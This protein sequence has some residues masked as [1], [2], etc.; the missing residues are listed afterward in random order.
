MSHTCKVCSKECT[1]MCTLC[2]SVYY[3]D[4]TCQR[5]D[6]KTHKLTCTGKNKA[7]PAPT[8]APTPNPASSIPQRRSTFNAR[9]IPTGPNPSPRAVPFSVDYETIRASD[10]S[11]MYPKNWTVGLMPDKSRV[12]KRFID[13]YRLRVEDEYV[14][15]RINRGLYTPEGTKDPTIP[16]NDFKKYIKKAEDKKMFPSWWSSEDTKAM[17]KMAM[18]DEWAD[19]NYAVEKS[20]VTKHYG[21][22]SLEHMNLRGL[23]ETIEGR[24]IFRG[25]NF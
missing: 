17:L 10:P 20:D 24:N 15:A 18:S 9:P 19:I 22:L 13:S 1:L 8:P 16:F 23:A 4:A 6:W 3:C 12:Y 7:S 25:C 11:L 2:K 5:T 21:Y 14:F